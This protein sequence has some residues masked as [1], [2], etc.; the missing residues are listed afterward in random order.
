MSVRKF[1][2]VADDSPERTAA[3]RYACRRAERVGGRVALLRTMDRAVFEHWSGVRE[4][5]ERQ[6]R[7]EAE[8][9]LQAMAEQVMTLT[10]QPAELL[11]RE[12]EPWPAIRAAVAED[13]DIKVLVLAAAVGGRGPGPLV[14]SVA[15]GGTGG[16]GRRLAVT[17]VP[18]DLTDAELID[19]TA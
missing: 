15:K 17:I 18:G 16:G 8:A 1:L 6:T 4:E 7:A 14:A 3:L 9:A 12:G 13:P 11:I 19:L 2:V 5:I 10:G